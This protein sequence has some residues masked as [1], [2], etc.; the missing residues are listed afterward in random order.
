MKNI[1]KNG[2]IAGLVM[3][4]A[5]FIGGA[6]LARLVYGPQMAP[7]GKFKASQ[8]NPFHFIW[9]KLVIGLIFGILFTF[10]YERLPLV[11]KIS[12]VFQGLKYAFCFWL[13][14]S[15]WNLSHPIV[16]ESFE[17]RKSIF[18]LLYTLCGFIALGGMLGFLYKKQAANQ[19]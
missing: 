6:I 5:L 13:I 16:Y 12:G 18:W 8:M 3:G 15:L 9:T 4:I 2:S 17:L 14:I 7:A 10:V 19:F 1:L 11:K